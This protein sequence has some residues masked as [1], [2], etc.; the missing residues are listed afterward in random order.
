MADKKDTP[1]NKSSDKADAKSGSA[2]TSADKKP[3]PLLDLKATEVRSATSASDGK[4]APTSTLKGA[5]G[6]KEAADKAKPDAGASTSKPP[7]TGSGAAPAAASSAASS[8]TSPSA[9]PAGASSSTPPRE[10]STAAKMASVEPPSGTAKKGSVDAASPSSGKPSATTPSSGTSKPATGKSQ[11]SKAAATKSGAPTGVGGS[12]GKPSGT[13][14]GATKPAAPPPARS[15]GGF[16]STLSH[17]AA[18]IVGGA[19]ALFAAEPIGQQFGVAL[20][21]PPKIPASVEKR[22]AALEARPAAANGDALR[23]DMAQLSDQ[24]AATQKRL[25]ELDTLGKQV[26]TLASDVEKSQTTSSAGSAPA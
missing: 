18:G 26:A 25:A 3:K 22:L 8:G 5:P 21:P 10:S 2:A 4:P 19:I 11:D 12:S 9:K 1:S 23:K 24:V 7:S 13:P 14:P 6:W 15:G 17:I 20:T 16:F